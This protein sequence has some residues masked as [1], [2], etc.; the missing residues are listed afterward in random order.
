MS[1][2]C[3]KNRKINITL[4]DNGNRMTR[5]CP[6]ESCPGMVE[7]KLVKTKIQKGKGSTWGPPLTIMKSVPCRERCM[8]A[9]AETTVDCSL[10]Q[11]PVP[12]SE[13]IWGMCCGGAESVCFTCFID[14]LEA[15]PTHMCQWTGS[16]SPWK[17]LVKVG[18]GTEDVWCRCP[19]GR[20]VWVH[21]R[22]FGYK[23]TK[24]HIKDWVPYGFIGDV[25][26]ETKSTYDLMKT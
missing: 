24:F 20:C 4:K 16:D 12:K 5:S 11:S 22:M 15:R 10:C 21:D 18:M 8:E 6:R 14:Y 26:L 2:F 25:K 13:M 19:V 7:A 1:E 3:K 23:D 9:C 17:K